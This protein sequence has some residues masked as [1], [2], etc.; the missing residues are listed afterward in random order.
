[1]SDKKV[2]FGLFEDEQVLM[3]AVKNVRAEGMK[4]TDVLTPF[5]VHGLDDAMGLRMTKLHSAGF[6]FGIAG[7]LTALVFIT[8]ISTMNYP[9]NYGGKPYFSLP[10]W[11]PI[12]FELTVLFSAV[13][14]TLTY[15]YL[16]RLAPG[17][18][19]KILDERITSHMFA[20]TFELDGQTAEN[21]KQEI[22]DVLIGNGAVEVYEKELDAL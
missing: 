13:G 20:M 12:T 8:W 11:I 22:R 18:K 6:I 16:N 2:L 1:M 17:M 3:K 10:A 21:K 9:I 7:T 14:M 5:P 19:P 4:I 15:M